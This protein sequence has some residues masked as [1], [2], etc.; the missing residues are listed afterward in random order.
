MF[1]M[2]AIRHGQSV[3]NQTNVIQGQTSTP[4]SELGLKQAAALGRRLVN[5]RFDAVYSSDLERAMQTARFAA[6]YME[7][8]P[9]VELRE[10]NLG[11]FQGLTRAQVE[12]R[13]PVEWESFLNGA[14]DFRIPDGESSIEVHERVV[15][16][17]KRLE[18]EVSG[19]R[20][21]VVSHCGAIRS[22]LK[23]IL[24]MENAWPI[25]PQLT[26]TAISRFICKEGLWQ[27]VTWNDTAHLDGLM[28]TA[29]NY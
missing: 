29:G 10:W 9:C 13:Y 12:E 11:I 16:F 15:G 28:P 21:L 7:P 24:G 14:P 1:E 18:T 5:V 2:F 22:M 23:H 25:R 6:P 19:G 4:L 8:I 17:L 26:N 3:A 20:I 27:L